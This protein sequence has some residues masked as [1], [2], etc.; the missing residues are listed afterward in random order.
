M[1]LD[2]LAKRL[3]ERDVIDRAALAQ[4]IAETESLP[5]ERGPQSH[6]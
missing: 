6:A 5:R 3:I 2:A 4:L 1:T